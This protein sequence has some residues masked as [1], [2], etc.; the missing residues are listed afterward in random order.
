MS[1][2]IFG[3]HF[4]HRITRKI[5]V[6][7]GS[8]FNEIQLVRYNKTGT[9]ELERVTVPIVYAQ[10]EKFY[11]R[12]KGDPNLLKSI[13]MMLPR[14]SFEIIG[15]EYD[16]TR[17]QNSMIRNT[18]P[19]TATNTTQKT[20]YAGVPYNYEFS[21]SI[22]V[23]NIEDGW[24]IVEQILPIFNPDYTLSIDLVSS[25]GITKDIP[26]VLNSVGYTVDSESSHD[27]DTTR[28]VIFDLLFTAKAM[29]FGP[30]TDSK[31]ITRANTNIYGMAS[32]SG[33]SSYG[34]EIYVIT[35][36]NNGFDTFK[37]GELVWQGDNYE[38]A[39]VKAEVVEHDTLNKKLYVKDIYGAKSGFGVFKSNVKITGASTGA[40]W[41][42]SSSYVSNVKLMIGI[43]VPDPINANVNSDF[44]FTETIIE[45]PNTLGL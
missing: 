8:L 24:Q 5:V 20:Q 17:K 25:M 38:F 2:G 21:V 22:Y 28:V 44:G 35:L 6:A 45:F 26:I 42:V 37:T 7:F 12:I 34:E 18:N 43:V 4:Y 3:N 32:N 14:I 23:R 9:T 40:S 39:D 31:I 19:A 36:Q 27:D 16:P 13:Q 1:T 29:L 41:N 30:V 33:K 11:N 10:K 15:L